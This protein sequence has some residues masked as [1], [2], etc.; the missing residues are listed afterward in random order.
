MA[1][2]RLLVLTVLGA[3]AW[4]F[5]LRLPATGADAWPL[6]EQASRA[7]DDPGVLWR[8][9]YLE[10]VPIGASFWRPLFVGAFALQWALFG[11]T[12]WP[13]H[14]LRLV[15]Y[16]LLAAGA[17]ALARRRP[18]A[19]ELAA[20]AA[21]ALVLLHPLQADM[22]PSL[23][24]SADV[25]VDLALCATLVLL[26][27]ER[28]SRG[29]LTLGTLAALA[30]PLVKESGLIAPLVGVAVLE[31]WRSGTSRGRRAAALALVAGLG[32]Q[33]ALR[34][35]RLGSVGSYAAGEAGASDVGGN[36]G[37]LVRGLADSGDTWLLAAPLAVAVAALAISRWGAE[38]AAAAPRDWLL[39]R[40]GALLWAALAVAG[41][42]ASPRL[43]E[44][45]AVALLVPLAVLVA[46]AL[47]ALPARA[48]R[49]RARAAAR[50]LLAL[51]VVGVLAPRSPLWRRYAQWDVIAAAS[52][53]VLDAAE[54]AARASAE[55]GAPAEG[56]V[57]VVRVRVARE[58]G[59]LRVAVAPFPLRAGPPSG[60]RVAALW[61]PMALMPYSVAAG[62]RM[63][64]V[65]GPIV[66]VPGRQLDVRPE[67]LAGD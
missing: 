54:Q 43:A 49:E 47:G 57:G 10:G 17:G 67:H 52:T 63:R 50:V 64:G 66:I 18:G 32:L 51:V 35:Q 31:P 45:H 12:A 29:A 6:L 4:G 15:A 20:L 65:P 26:A 14:A 30:A 56:N 58:R 27:R 16:L 33:V 13:Y 36:L 44:R 23:A 53:G 61:Q 19:G 59:A 38:P 2:R 25:L 3:W 7:L 40:R 8:E 41:A 24:R 22:L 42:L 48:G 46:P 37:R 62:L 60:P 21:G 28:P 1:L 55:R 5:V 39:T 34:W 11:A 9:R